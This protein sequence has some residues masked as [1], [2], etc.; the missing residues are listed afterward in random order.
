MIKPKGLKFGDTIGLIA[1]ASPVEEEKIKKSQRYLENLGFKVKLGKSCFSK[2]GYLAG[3]D[4]IRSD[5][6]N[7][8]F[9]DKDIQGI[10]CARGG[11]GCLRIL[12]K[13]DYSMI[14]K[15]PKIFMGYSDI[16]SLHIAL[17]QKSNLATFH[18]PMAASNMGD[19]LDDLSRKSMFSAFKNR[20][21]GCINN[22]QKEL[23]KG[24]NSGSCSGKITGGNLSLITASLGT[25]YEIDTRGKLL[26]IEEIGEAPYKI[27]RM[28]TQLKHSKKLHNCKG[29][30]LGDFNNCEAGGSSL[31]LMEIILDTLGN[32]YK[33]IVYNIKSGHCS[34]NITIPLG[35]KSKIDAD[36]GVLIIEESAVAK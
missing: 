30:I 15:N 18:G 14:K 33:P 34:P 4:N 25:N 16:T 21:I 10:I 9:Y 31:T 12:D 22:M 36:M 24:I 29:F 13:I 32:T 20:P 1:P 3:N 19:G 8:M 26:F 28:L 27:D 35:I 7:K 5:D 2:Y 6:I 17:N 23:I 11:Y